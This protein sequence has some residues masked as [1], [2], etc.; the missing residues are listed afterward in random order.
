M[1]S[2]NGASELALNHALITATIPDNGTLKTLRFIKDNQIIHTELIDK[3]TLDIVIE[4]L[5]LDAFLYKRPLNSVALHLIQH[6]YN[7]YKKFKSTNLKLAKLH[8][9]LM[10]SAMQLTL[11]SEFTL[12]DGASL[13][14]NQVIDLIDKEVELL[15]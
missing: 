15:K 8:L 2:T 7:L 3:I 1:I 13:S 12:S 5:N 4:N 6:Q 14:K 9:F 10:K 11:K